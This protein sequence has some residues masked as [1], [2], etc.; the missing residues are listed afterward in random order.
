MSEID[1][2][3][4]M[5]T[6]DVIESVV[7]CIKYHNIVPIIGPEVFY[8][9]DTKKGRITV[10]EYI[11]NC[12]IDDD[13]SL[14]ESDKDKIR[15]F[16]KITGFN[17]LTKVSCYYT[18][19]TKK[20]LKQGMRKIL[21]KKINFSIIEMEEEV[22]RFLRL[23][24][25]P[26]IITTL[27]FND[28]I[29]NIIKSLYGENGYNEIIYKKAELKPEIILDNKCNVFFI[30][31]TLD[32]YN[33]T[34]VITEND[35]LDYLHCIHDSNKD[36]KNLKSYM[37]DKMILTLGCDIPDWTFRFLLSSFKPIEMKEPTTAFEGGVV[38]NNEDKNLEEFLSY[39]NYD[40][41][42]KGIDVFLREIN[43]AIER[44]ENEEK[45]DRPTIFL[46]YSYDLSNYDKI[47]KIK[48][49]L[50][51]YFKVNF[52]GI[53]EQENIGEDFWGVIF[54]MLDESDYF[55]PVITNAMVLELGKLPESDFDKEITK[56][57]GKGFVTE[58]KYAALKCY[59]GKKLKGQNKYS[60][61]LLLGTDTT[62]MGHN[63]PDKAKEL[64]KD[65]I[66]R[67]VIQYTDFSVQKV[68]KNL[69]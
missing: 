56:L 9:N 68:L 41:T 61:P 2:T 65:I 67:Q 11:I 22:K 52:Y 31:G 49:E 3:N 4:K 19:K 28:V 66:T 34:V 15:E 32:S 55:I 13:A 24:D 35:F 25:F 45:I 5:W 18:K 7:G 59:E 26:L 38:S 29:K 46:S 64:F 37:Q 54:K 53:D 50:E 48:E 6:E 42:D 57:E 69:Q 58:W 44:K 21:D 8:V 63:I 1:N 43:D 16:A 17:G 39:I 40:Y 36:P 62:Y 23:G 20:S 60:I 10:Q 47:V 51:K 14:E 27:I 30:L 33:A 12:L